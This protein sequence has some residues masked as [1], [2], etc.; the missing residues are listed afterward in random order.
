MLRAMEESCI[1][2]RAR[3]SQAQLRACNP[4]RTG[5]LSP[6]SGQTSTPGQTGSRV[7]S[8]LSA[9]VRSLSQQVSH[10]DLC[11]NQQETVSKPAGLTSRLM[12]QSTRDGL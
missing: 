8:Q 4:L 12:S 1:A 3:A 10:L 11:L 7:V 2:G 6:V 5:R 9:A